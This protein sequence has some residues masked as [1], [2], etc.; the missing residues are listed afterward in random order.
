M[1]KVLEI[2]SEMAR[3]PAW[4]CL[5]RAHKH[6][7]SFCAGFQPIS[8]HL[9]EVEEECVLIVSRLW[10]IQKPLP[11]TRTLQLGCQVCWLIEGL[12]FFPSSGERLQ[13]VTWDHQMTVSQ[14]SLPYGTILNNGA[15]HESNN[16]RKE[17]VV[18]KL[19]IIKSKS[20]HW[21]RNNP[22]YSSKYSLT[23]G[24]QM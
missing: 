2:L 4:V 10:V 3:P 20:T 13:N 15:S 19:L 6:Q 16:I 7:L 24:Q 21:L 14:W 22:G 8:P 11:W 5:A 12:I 17:I 1:A 23:P 18:S 9:V